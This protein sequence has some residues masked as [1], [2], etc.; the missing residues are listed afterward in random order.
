MAGW[1]AREWCRATSTVLPP[2]LGCSPSSS[3]YFLLSLQGQGSHVPC[4]ADTRANNV[5]RL[6]PNPLVCMCATLG[7][8]LATHTSYLHREC[9]QPNV[10]TPD[11]QH[12]RPDISH[13]T[14]DCAARIVWFVQRA[15]DPPC[16]ACDQQRSIKSNASSQRRK[17]GESHRR[18]S[19]DAMYVTAARCIRPSNVRQ[20]RQLSK[21]ENKKG[22]KQPPLVT[23]MFSLRLARPAKPSTIRRQGG[24]LSNGHLG[25][26][27][28]SSPPMP[29]PA[30]S[31]PVLNGKVA[32]QSLSAR[33]FHTR[34]TRAFA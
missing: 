7:R 31:M 9:S 30:P 17:Y 11:Q 29:P 22:K 8:H 24:R 32:G 23:S 2:S 27:L 10:V 21:R 5:S 18:A 25:P 19:L 34:R 12:A 33:N 16:L 26:I 20:W 4:P 3:P 1:P 6:C 15:L 14:G 28:A 13:R